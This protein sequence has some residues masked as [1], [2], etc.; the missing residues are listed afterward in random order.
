[1]TALKLRGV[2]LLSGLLIGVLAGWQLGTGI[3]YGR[4]IWEGMFAEA[5]Y[6][7]LSLL[8]YDQ[9]DTG[10]ARQALVSF[11][12]FSKSMGKVPSTQGNKSLLIDT[13][14]AYLKLAALEELAGDGALSHQYVLKAQESFRSMGRDIPE[15]QLSEDVKKIAAL[16]R[17]NVPPS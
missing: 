15:E 9:A 1:M 4:L 7:Q 8:Q 10:H 3:T 14:R 2:A 6:S 16:P 13:G 12:D 11:T 5:G 17:P